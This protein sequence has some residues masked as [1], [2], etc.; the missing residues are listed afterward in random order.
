[1]KK[2]R[3]CIITGY[4]INADRELAEAFKCVGGLAQRIHI[5]ELLKDPSQLEE[6]AVAA[7]P[8][9]FSFGDHL[10]SGKVFASLL[11]K[12]LKSNLTEF[13]KKGKLIIGICN[14]FQT[15]VKMGI[16]PNLAGNWQQEVS[17]IHNDSGVFEDRWVKLRFDP[18]SPCVWTRGMDTL[19]VPVRH[20]EG[21]LITCN[22]QILDSILEQHLGVCFYQGPQGNPA[23]YPFNPNGSVCDL[24]GICDPSGQIFGLMPHPEVFLIPEHHPAWTRHKNVAPLGLLLFEQ[25]LRYLRQNL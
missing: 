22:K 16:L 25:G 10:G 4:G 6:Y 13:I 7:F 1:M 14:G 9:G 5:R 17:L 19:E 18:A 3:V 11:K 24:A 23:G 12:F 15:L 21:K 8:G 2:I 20:G